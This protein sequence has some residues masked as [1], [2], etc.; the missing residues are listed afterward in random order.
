MRSWTFWFWSKIWLVI[1]LFRLLENDFIKKFTSSTLFSGHLQF[2]SFQLFH[3]VL[4]VDVIA[5]KSLVSSFSVRP[6][7]QDLKWSS[8]SQRQITDL[9]QKPSNLMICRWLSGESLACLSQNIISE[10]QLKNDTM[11]C[12]EYQRQIKATSFQI[13][14]IEII[15]SL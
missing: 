15:C 12:M 2:S 9:N 6:H 1:Y 14:K 11:K 8:L 4:S 7:V 13:W 10:F 5:K 3:I